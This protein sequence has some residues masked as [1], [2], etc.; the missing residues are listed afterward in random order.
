[1]EAEKNS[2]TVEPDHYYSVWID[3][4]AAE[5]DHEGNPK[6]KFQIDQLPRSSDDLTSLSGQN[7]YND[8]TPKHEEE[9]EITQNIIDNILKSNFQKK[10]KSKI[11][12]VF[13]IERRKRKSKSKFSKKKQTGDPR[14]QIMDVIPLD[15]SISKDNKGTSIMT[16]DLYVLN[17]E[18]SKSD[19]QS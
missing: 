8:E 3:Q 1:M 14:I 18:K 9:K 7:I 2:P 16:Q 6:E 10:P 15:E 11:E 19:H 5:I 13:K 12:Q 17:L 4:N